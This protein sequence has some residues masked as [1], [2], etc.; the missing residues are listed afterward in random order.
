VDPNLRLWP[1]GDQEKIQ[2]IEEL[3]GFKML[4]CDAWLLIGNFNLITKAPNKNNLNINMHLVGK[5]RSP[6]LPRAQRYAHGW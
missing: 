3:C 6:R 2:F 1:R 5:I 4:V